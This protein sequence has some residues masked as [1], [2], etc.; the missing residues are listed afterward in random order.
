MP[1]L[2]SVPITTDDTTAEFPTIIFSV[3]LFNTRS[4]DSV[5]G[6]VSS[7]YPLSVIF[8][9]YPNPNAFNPDQHR[10]KYTFGRFYICIPLWRGEWRETGRW[11][12][13]VRG[14]RHVA[15]GRRSVDLSLIRRNILSTHKPRLLVWSFEI[16]RC[17]LFMC[18]GDGFQ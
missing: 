1:G 15:D 16:W 13:E 10:I 3:S 12:E 11:V 18:S 4:G 9:Q 14:N 7:R 17:T 6:R 5:G 2:Q 8:L